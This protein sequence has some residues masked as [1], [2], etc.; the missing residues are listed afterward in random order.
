MSGFVTGRSAASIL[1]RATAVLAA[2]FMTTSIILAILAS[3]SE[4]PRSIVDEPAPTQEE[5]GPS[6]P[7]APVR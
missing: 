1:T 2:A 7:S 6:S 3:S 5:S 4:E